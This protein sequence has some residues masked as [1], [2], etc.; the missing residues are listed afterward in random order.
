MGRLPYRRTSVEMEE[1]DHGIS[2][3]MK[4]QTIHYRKVFSYF[5]QT[6]LGLSKV[7][8]FFESHLLLMGQ[9]VIEERDKLPT[10]AMY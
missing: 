6:I 4:I 9:G 8:R 2:S 10:V 7:K 5:S 1:A 3:L